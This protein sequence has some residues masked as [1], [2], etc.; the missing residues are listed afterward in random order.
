MPRISP[1]TRATSRR[2]SSTSS[3]VAAA[4]TSSGSTRAAP[5]R[6]PSARIHAPE[7]VVVVAAL[8]D[9]ITEGSPGDDSRRGG[10]ETSQWEYWAAGRNPGLHFRNC[11]IYGERTDEI[12]KRL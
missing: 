6:S 3:N 5:H 11:G 1:S 2:R 8:G 10:D 12:M 4:T 7:G 9:S